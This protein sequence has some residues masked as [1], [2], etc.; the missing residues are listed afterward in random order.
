MG[1]IIQG[2]G[3]TIFTRAVKHTKTLPAY[4]FGSQAGG[5]L[6]GLIFCRK[7]AAKNRLTGNA[8]FTTKTDSPHRTGKPGADRFFLAIRLTQSAGKSHI[9][10]IEAMGDYCA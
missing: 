7:N 1:H 10:N 2:H 5:L 4:F 9:L 8:I 6:Q 3:L